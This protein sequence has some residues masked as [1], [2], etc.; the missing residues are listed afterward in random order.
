MD[1]KS[2][3]RI[4]LVLIAKVR[5]RYDISPRAFN[6]LQSYA[7]IC[8]HMHSYAFRLESAAIHQQAPE[9]AAML[10]AQPFEK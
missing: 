3:R 9:P 6:I 8:I 5:L 4:V 1:L 2:G 7:I 10:I